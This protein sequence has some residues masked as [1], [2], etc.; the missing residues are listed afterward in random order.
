[1]NGKE[2]GSM[3]DLAISFLEVNREKENMK[4]ST[5]EPDY[6]T[7]YEKEKAKWEALE[8]FIL[9][10]EYTRQFF[11]KEDADMVDRDDILRMMKELVT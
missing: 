8:T 10:Q 4:L 3:L 1:M 2:L 11:L 6:K 5:S 9:N 7:L